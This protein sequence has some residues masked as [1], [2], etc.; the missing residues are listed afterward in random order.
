MRT[1]V[2]TKNI[3]NSGD[4]DDDAYSFLFTIILVLGILSNINY[5]SFSFFLTTRP[6]DQYVDGGRGELPTPMLILLVPSWMRIHS[7]LIS[8]LVGIFPSF[9][10]PLSSFLHL[11]TFLH[12]VGPPFLWALGSVFGCVDGTR[13]SFLCLPFLFSM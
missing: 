3:D 2:L 5:F 10:L 8:L 9:P 13:C 7:L 1:T 12:L 4:D 11:Y 6:V